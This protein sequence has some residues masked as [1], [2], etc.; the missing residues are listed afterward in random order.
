MS[1]SRSLPKSIYWV[2]L[3]WQSYEGVEKL[4][5]CHRER[6]QGAWRS[7]NNQRNRDCFV[8]SLLAMTKKRVSQRSPYTLLTRVYI[9][10]LLNIDFN[11]RSCQN[12]Q[13][14][15]T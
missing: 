6:P 7:L 1:G 13:T 8:A 12:G 11:T 3:F 10:S 4:L 9:L 2:A 14:F 15:T 5:N